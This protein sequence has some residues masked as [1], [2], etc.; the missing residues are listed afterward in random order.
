MKANN[1][2]RAHELMG[3]F[4]YEVWK[5]QDLNVHEMQTMWFEYQCSNAFY[6][7]NDIRMALK[8]IGWIEKHFDTN[9]EDCFEFNN[10]A[11]RKGTVNHQIGVL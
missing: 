10:Y 9:I 11:L 2:E 1:I 7:K 4:S 6:R 3:M 5:G 8:Q